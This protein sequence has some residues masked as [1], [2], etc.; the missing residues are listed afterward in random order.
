MDLRSA[1]C[2]LSLPEAGTEFLRGVV[3]LLDEDVVEF[4]RVAL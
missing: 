3:D 4:V 1:I 2:D